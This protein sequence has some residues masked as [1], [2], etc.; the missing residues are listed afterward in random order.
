MSLR[1]LPGGQ[2]G[3]VCSLTSLFIRFFFPLVACA[4]SQ[5]FNHLEKSQGFSS[6][7]FCPVHVRVSLGSGSVPTESKNKDYPG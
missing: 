5:E 1:S 4:G 6:C 2:R 3:Q 7:Y